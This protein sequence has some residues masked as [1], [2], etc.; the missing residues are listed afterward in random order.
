MVSLTDVQASNSRIATALPPRLVA[1]FVGATSG[2]GE[3]TLKQFVKHTCR[4]RVY[5]VGRS[6]EAGERI[7]AECEAL[8][9][10]GEFVFVK[11]DTSLIRNVDEV[12]HDIKNKEK[13]VNLLFLSTGSLIFNTETPEGL[14][15]AMALATYSR[16]RFI[17]NLLPLLQQATG[18][19]RVVSV[20]TAGKE[21][22]VDTSNIQGRKMSMLSQRRHG[23]SL[24]TLS[25]EALS[26]KAPDVAF[27]HN[28]PG[29]VR[30]GMA[31]GTTGAA[32]FVFKAVFAVAGPLLYMPDQECGE[33]HLF[34]ATSARYPA[35]VTQNAASGVPLADG[36]AVARGTNAQSG[37]GIYSLDSHGESSGPKVEELLAKFRKHGMVETVWKDTQE[38]FMRIT[39]TLAV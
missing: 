8:N 26:Q 4:P 23:S 10:E 32:M 38:Q 11:A 6:Q 7:T 3:A 19:R 24:V 15:F 5:F 12:C 36:V 35:G 22:P 34:L 20:F 27:I 25:L 31:R 17:V 21:G 16:T 1:V 14:H 29:V 33:R 2:I 37:S 9:S 18:L 30:G 28:F 39:G 13:V